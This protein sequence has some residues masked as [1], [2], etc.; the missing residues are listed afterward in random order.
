[1]RNTPVTMTP[2]MFRSSL[3]PMAA[4]CLTL[5]SALGLGSVL[6]LADPGYLAA[7]SEKILI[8]GIRTASAHTTWMIIHI[9]VSV[10]CFVFPAVTAAGIWMTLRGKPA[11]GMNFLSNT[12]RGL[13]GLV[14]ISGW[15]ALAV[16]L[17]RATLYILSLLRRQDWIY[18]LFAVFVME[19]L[20]GSQAVFLHRML[21]RFLDACDGCAASIGY[22]LSSGK[23]DPGSIPAFAATGLLILGIAGLVLSADRLI[24]MT[25]GYDGFK[26]F[27]KFVWSAHPGQWLCAA[28]LF[29]GG[30]GDILLALY[31]KFYKRTSERTI[32]FAQ[33]GT[34]R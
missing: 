29:V 20:M 6:Y 11:K 19:G 23:L 27:Y 7:V 4:V 30:I 8:S 31:L 14:H 24:T 17:I 33:R 10:I 21:C 5:A 34:Q 9:V 3:A 28:T 2:G 32:F 13:L 22:T 26:Q 12:A 15:I 1:M 18:Q 16:F 25:I